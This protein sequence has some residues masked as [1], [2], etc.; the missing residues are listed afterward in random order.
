MKKLIII[1]FTVILALPA[2]DVLDIKPTNMISEQDVKNDPI[3][4][5]AYLT[6]VYNSVRW[7]SGGRSN[8]MAVLAVCGGE[9]NVFAGWQGPYRT[10]MTIIDENGAPGLLDYWPYGNIRSTN[11]II[12]ILQNSDTGFDEEFVQQKSAEARFLRAFMYFELVKRYG[13]IPLITEPQSIDQP[14]EE[15]YVKRAPE[16]EVYDFIANEMDDISR[17]LPSSYGTDDFGRATKWAALA[18]KSRAMLYAASIAQFSD[19]TLPEGVVGIPQSKAQD[20]WQAAYDASMEIINESPHAL[21]NHNPDP[22]KNYAEIFVKDGNE[23]VIFAEVYNLSL[24]KTHSWN[25][26]YMPD[27]F[28]T[29]W[30]SNGPI[31]LEFVEKYEYENGSPGN[32][33]WNDLN[34]NVLFDIDSIMAD[35]DPRFRASIFYPE[36]PWQGSVVYFHSKTVG[37]ID[38]ESGWPSKAPARNY[39]K[40]GFLL[41]KRINESVKLPISM[42]DETDWIVFRMGEIYLNAA[43]AA[44]YLNKNGESLDLLNAIRE[45]AGMPDKTEVTEEIIRNERTVELA[46]EEHHYWD[47]RRWRTA[48]QELNGKGFHGVSWVYNFPEHKYTM[49][50]KSGEYGDVRTFQE[51]HYYLPL[52][53]DRLA[54]NPNLVENPGYTNGGE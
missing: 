40:S 27:G 3:L 7:Q 13:G 18:L 42:E 37:T 15:L 25:F 54:D 30:G 45:R 41:R 20:Y 49:K 39:K 48:V 1:I 53:I 33:N 32:L 43:E 24:L 51:K 4:L 21:Y 44:F 35:R 38:S 29:G 26:L 34:G 28:R 9:M 46:F 31:Y 17:I 16:A 8:N 36:T 47:L 11:E 6:N 52:G 23:E 10:A 12:Q 50:L 2:C 19:I 14:I 5:D 22:Q